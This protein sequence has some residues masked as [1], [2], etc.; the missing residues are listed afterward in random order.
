M[1]VQV[2]KIDREFIR[3]VDG[4][5]LLAGMVRAMIE[6]AESLEMTPVA[7]GIETEEEHRFLRSIG[8][9]LGQG[10]WFARPMPAERLSSLA[11]DGEL[12]LPS[13]RPRG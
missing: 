9:T 2:L 3:D 6:V 13:S 1:P 8:C 5:A 4:N 10:F 12:R 11:V 7:V